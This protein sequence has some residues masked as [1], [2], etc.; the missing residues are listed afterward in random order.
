MADASLVLGRE[1]TGWTQ[2]LVASVIYG[3][4]HL[5]AALPPKLRTLGRR[6]GGLDPVAAPAPKGL[7]RG[8]EAEKE[9]GLKDCLF[10]FRLTSCRLQALERSVHPVGVPRGLSRGEINQEPGPLG[11]RHCYSLRFILNAGRI[12][13]TIS[14]TEFSTT[15]TRWRSSAF[16]SPSLSM[17]A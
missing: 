3:G 4:T 15:P 12:S 1:A 10:R 14:P 7:D 11:D 2:V 8:R 17:P 16:S 9:I 13:P 5:L 6:L